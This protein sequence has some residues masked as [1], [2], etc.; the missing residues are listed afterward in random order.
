MKQPSKL[1]RN[2]KECVSAHHLNAKEWAFVE[3][4]GSYLKIINKRTGKIKLIDKYVR[5]VR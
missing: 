2:Q 1:T 5:K 4:V 3:E